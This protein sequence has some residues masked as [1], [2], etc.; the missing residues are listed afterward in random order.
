MHMQG[1][2]HWNLNLFGGTGI[3]ETYPLLSTTYAQ[4]QSDLQAI[5]T[6]RAACL[7]ALDVTL[8]GSLISDLDVFQDSQ[9]TGI[10][11]GAPGTYAAQ[12]TNRAPNYALGSLF[13]A[14]TLRR[15]TRWIH[16]VP[17]D[18]VVAGGVYT[19]TTTYSNALAA[20]LGVIQSKCAI[21]TRLKGSTPP[22]WTFNNITA[23]DP[24]V[25]RTRRT[26]R[27][28]GA[29]RGRQRIR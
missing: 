6:A 12:P 23:W 13:H 10:A 18:C 24:P 4:A 20:Y 16:F 8:G 25:V 15:G 22:T 21:A 19:P 27:P 17:A 29:P 11:R 3:S 1:W 14:G 28:F 2:L 5:E 26:G 7:S 9:P